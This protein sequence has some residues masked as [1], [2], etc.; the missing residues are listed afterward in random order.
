M[1]ILDLRRA[2][3][4]L[5]LDRVEESRIDHGSLCRHGL[6]GIPFCDSEVARSGQLRVGLTCSPVCCTGCAVDISCNPS[7]AYFHVGLVVVRTRLAFVRFGTVWTVFYTVVPPGGHI[8]R[9]TVYSCYSVNSSSI[10][11]TVSTLVVTGHAA[12]SYVWLLSTSS[13]LVFA[14]LTCCL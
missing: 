8:Q 12:G 4:R 11:F 14:W 7:S 2:C 13:G 9:A 10:A 3:L 5:S 1:A 6:H